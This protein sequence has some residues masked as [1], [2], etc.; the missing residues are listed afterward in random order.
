MLQFY[1]FEAPFPA[2]FILNR[3]VL[4]GLL[5][6]LPF[7]IDLVMLEPRFPPFRIPIM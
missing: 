2:L 6:F 1:C 5:T 4:S 7:Y 3:C